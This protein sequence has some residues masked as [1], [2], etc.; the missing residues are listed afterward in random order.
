MN[1]VPNENPNIPHCVHCEMMVIQYQHCHETGCPNENKT[2]DPERRDWV[3][4]TTGPNGKGD[5]E[6]G[7]PCR[8]CLVQAGAVSR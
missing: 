8:N 3:E 1:N 6:V 2:W 4:N 5:V 7:E